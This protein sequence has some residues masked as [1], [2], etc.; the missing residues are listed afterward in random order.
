MFVD[1]PV[2]NVVIFTSPTPVLIWEAVDFEELFFA[3]ARHPSKVPCIGQPARRNRLQSFS[4]YTF[5]YKIWE[6]KTL[7]SSITHSPEIL[8]LM[9]TQMVYSCLCPFGMVKSFGFPLDLIFVS[10]LE[11]KHYSVGSVLWTEPFSQPTEPFEFDKISSCMRDFRE[12][13]SPSTGDS[14]VS[15]DIRSFSQ[16]S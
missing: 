11:W 13:Q 15:N 10:S 5:Q 8:P 3:K 14:T 6:R 2:V 9:T 16:L 1:L 12:P 7:L 4:W